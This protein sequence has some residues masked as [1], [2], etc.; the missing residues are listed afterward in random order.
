MIQDL[1]LTNSLSPL[2]VLE[3]VRE[4]II[5]LKNDDPPSAVD[6][7]SSLREYFTYFENSSQQLGKSNI[8]HC[9]DLFDVIDHVFFVKV[10]SKQ[11]TEENHEL[12]AS[13]I[14]NFGQLLSLSFQHLFP[15]CCLSSNKSNIMFIVKGAFEL[16]HMSFAK[17]FL[18]GHEL[19]ETS[20]SIPNFLFLD[21][22]CPSELES[23]GFSFKGIKPFEKL[24]KYQKLIKNHQIGTVIWLS[25]PVTISLFLGSRF[26]KNQI[27]WSARYRNHL[28]STVDKYF[29]GARGSKKTINY[30]GVP[31]C[32]GRFHAGEWKGL[33]LVK[34]SDKCIHESDLA[35]IKF[36]E[37]KKSQGFTIAA[38]VS[39]DRKLQSLEFIE[40][41]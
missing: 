8:Q 32:Y 39:T 33:T 22:E 14:A 21:T 9:I 7:S 12:L 28:F 20:T 37:R 2:S 41:S 27:Y 24:K 5:S 26:V 23:K 13:S 1:C 17:S 15:S 4:Y 18:L 38:T 16:A 19:N 36:L 11:V 3:K 6:I 35:W 40:V 31:W 34:P 29:F 25:A 10:L 30:N